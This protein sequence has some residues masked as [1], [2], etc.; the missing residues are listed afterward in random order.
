MLSCAVQAQQGTPPEMTAG[1]SLMAA[2]R[3]PAL[4][5]PHTG[6]GNPGLF[7]FAPPTSGPMGA[8]PPSPQMPGAL[9][10]CTQPRTHRGSCLPAQCPPCSLRD[11][12]CMKPW[13]LPPQLPKLNI[14]AGSVHA[15]VACK[16]GT[17]SAQ[18]RR[19]LALLSGA[20]TVLPRRR[21]G[22]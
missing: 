2:A 15:C 5:A 3:N 19:D 7:G 6:A 21:E 22:Q 18:V 8:A 4:F 9:H 13:L 12:A 17:L 11:I 20:L 1:I 10:A 14:E 16:P